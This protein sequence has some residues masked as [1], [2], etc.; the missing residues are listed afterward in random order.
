M[1][2]Q[3]RRPQPGGPRR[4]QGP[5]GIGIW[6]PTDPDD[7]AIADFSPVEGDFLDSRGGNNR[8][9][10][11]VFRLV[12]EVT[13][14]DWSDDLG[15]QAESYAA[16]GIP[17]Y[18]IADRHHDEVVVCRDPREGT[19]RLRTTHKRGTSIGAPECVGVCL[20]LPVDLLLDGITG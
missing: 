6:L 8:Y 20:E 4:V 11:E 9:S 18:I 1:R 15:T 12:V 16:A 10:P 5:Q 17:V 2:H 14:S 19:C 13:S 3:G 7:Y